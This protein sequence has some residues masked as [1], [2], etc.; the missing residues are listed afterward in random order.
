MKPSTGAAVRNHR[1][2]VRDRSES[3][4]AINRKHCPQS[5]E[6]AHVALFIDQAGWHKANDL[7]FPEN[8]TPIPLPPYSPELNP[9][10]R[11]WEYLKERYLS[12]R[13]LDDYDA[14]VDAAC[15][16]WNKLTG[17]SGRLTSLTWL[18]WA[19]ASQ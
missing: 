10:E 19:E 16:A 15:V 7:K 5:P 13:L 18:P 9:A 12:H 11:V 14:I 8:I 2:A 1:N 4:S 3:V 6:S 17:E